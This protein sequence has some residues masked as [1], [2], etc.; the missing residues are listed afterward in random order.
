[1]LV[2]HLA[3]EL[4]IFLYIFFFISAIVSTSPCLWEF[5]F[6]LVPVYLD[7]GRAVP[8]D[9]TASGANLTPCLYFKLDLQ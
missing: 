1:M 5:N 2:Q 4:H 3:Y 7:E 6:Q 9:G 8:T